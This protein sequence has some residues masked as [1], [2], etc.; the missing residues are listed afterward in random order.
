MNPQFPIAFVLPVGCRSGVL[1]FTTSIKSH[2]PS[3]ATLLL[4]WASAT[5]SPE[6]VVVQTRASEVELADGGT[7][8]SG[9]DT[10]PDIEVRTDVQQGTNKSSESLQSGSILVFAPTMLGGETQLRNLEV[11]NNGE[12]TMR[13]LSLSLSGPNTA[14]FTWNNNDVRSTIQSYMDYVAQNPSSGYYQVLNL[15]ITFT[16][17]HTGL[18]TATLSIISDDPDESPFVVK[19]SG[20]GVP[21]SPRLTV[22]AKTNSSWQEGDLF[23]LGNVQP[24]SSV[25]AT[26]TLQN[27]GTRPMPLTT[28]GLEKLGPWADEFEVSAAPALAPGAS[29][30]VNVTAR[31]RS[32]G[33][34]WMTLRLGLGHEVRFVLTAAYGPVAQMEFSWTNWIGTALAERSDGRTL[35]AGYVPA[36]VELWNRVN[37]RL[38]DHDGAEIPGWVQPSITGVTTSST[39]WRNPAGSVNALV[40][41]DH[42][43]VLVAGS[44]TH[45]NDAPRQGIARL[46][47]DGS[48]DTGFVPPSG[49]L[50]ARA[51]VLLPDGKIL[52]GG[53]GGLGVAPSR[54]TNLL[55]L[56]ADGS[57]DGTFTPTPP[58]GAINALAP[59]PDG[60][61]LAG[62]D[63][64][65]LSWGRSPSGPGS[66]LRTNT[67]SIADSLNNP[68]PLVQLTPGGTLVPDFVL[69]WQ[70]R[71]LD[72]DSQG[73]SV[74]MTTEE[75]QTIHWIYTG[76]ATGPSS[77]IE[78]RQVVATRDLADA[79]G[80]W[81]LNASN[82]NTRPPQVAAE[83]NQRAWTVNPTTLNGS[84]FFTAHA[85]E[86]SEYIPY[87]LRAHSSTIS[88]RQAIPRREGESAIGDILVRSDGGLMMAGTA[89]NAGIAHRQVNAAAS[90]VRAQ[91]GGR[92]LANGLSDIPL[93]PGQSVEVTVTLPGD[94]IGRTF[95]LGVATIIGN[96]GAEFTA[97]ITQVNTTQRT[98]QV[99]RLASS[100][101]VSALRAVLQV[102]VAQ[103]DTD[104]TLL[105]D[106][107]AA[108]RAARYAL[109]KHL[110][111][112]VEDVSLSSIRAVQWPDSSLGLG[113]SAF[114]VI[115]PGWSV[116]LEAGGGSYILR[117]DRRGTLV[118][119]AVP[120]SP[121]A[122]RAIGGGIYLRVPTIREASSV[123]P[124]TAAYGLRDA[125]NLP[126]PSVQL[127]HVGKALQPGQILRLSEDFLELGASTTTNLT[128]TNSGP[129]PLT[130]FHLSLSAN[131]SVF[132]LAPSSSHTPLAP[133]D[134][135]DLPVC[136]HSVTAGD[137]ITRLLFHSDQYRDPALLQLRATFAPKFPRFTM[138]NEALLTEGQTLDLET[139]SNVVLHLLHGSRLIN[140]TPHLGPVTFADA[141]S[142][143]IR[144]SD[145]SSIR[146]VLLPF[147]IGVVRPGF[148]QSWHLRPSTRL[149][150]EAA[151]PDLRFQW[152][153]DGKPIP[154]AESPILTGLGQSLANIGTY[155]CEV[156]M[157]GLP[158]A[159]IITAPQTLAMALPPVV[160]DLAPLTAMV[161]QTLDI[162]LTATESPTLWQAS[163]LPF[164]LTLNAKAGRITGRC[165]AAGTFIIKVQA[166]N[167]DGI[168]LPRSFTLNVLPLPAESVGRFTALL[169]RDSEIN[170]ERGGI[171]DLTITT[172]G[173]CTGKLRISSW[174]DPR[175]E[176]NAAYSFR[177]TMLPQA[178]GSLSGTAKINRHGNAGVLDLVFSTRGKTL[179][180]HWATEDG[181]L[182][183]AGHGARRLTTVSPP[184][185]K[186]WQFRMEA[187]APE[188]NRGRCSVALI[189]TRNGTF[190][191]A[192]RLSAS[193]HPTQVFTSSGGVMDGGLVQSWS[194]GNDRNKRSVRSV[195]Q[196]KPKEGQFEA[197]IDWGF[198]SHTPIDTTR[199]MSFSTPDPGRF[200]LPASKP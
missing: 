51:I 142:Y 48:L 2:L 144:L 125:E 96:D 19:L 34:R 138:P 33:P 78:T 164:G 146:D 185:T 1:R 100:S 57:L 3:I 55:R 175:P 129:V 44:F 180:V 106:E 166:I 189:I 173:A 165:Q 147:R 112:D 27:T 28:A 63:A 66:W 80:E 171:L 194:Q 115:T 198:G 13:Q 145:E 184:L 46:L 136:V 36:T 152:L 67:P 167:Q 10:I 134:S 29:A 148:Q 23:R 42:Q 200:S 21:A 113:A 149:V 77:T 182:R 65:G 68:C 102:Q 61:F 5:A 188:D 64:T 105:S 16:P 17:G 155:T 187:D 163:G 18:H 127:S 6:I 130:N 91:I 81:A 193:G 176:G 153:R 108:T 93:S 41:D 178:D 88:V 162:S 109:A 82:P 169:I 121:L 154:G 133:G 50:A 4:S 118:G 159:R 22:A 40:V 116:S 183:E 114:Q 128:L 85:N 199:G 101:R 123:A 170:A 74:A 35:V 111:L 126:P 11:N 107:L 30:D 76:W 192:Q 94:S 143:R 120:S 119:L 26:L 71:V 49:D 95:D 25:T 191:L 160:Q 131:N 196:H 156:T 150:V 117:T 86:P 110:E 181:D 98:V 9:G 90:Q 60:T 124:L 32:I 79:I 37:I 70:Q 190:V 8:G 53:S 59:L 73:W 135:I 168:S 104:S 43:R 195:L 72:L 97:N 24:G 12:R 174:S 179:N 56:N 69:R 54:Q 177:S 38:L 47:A 161:T 39:S 103:L 151:G 158:N 132:N 15:P 92:L 87:L 122:I 157:D 7:L 99:T 197:K 14:A 52:V 141:G 31:P 84:P 137:F 139:G 58:D 186:A 140:R 83:S 62:G 20:E 89:A 172:T 45:V 75:E